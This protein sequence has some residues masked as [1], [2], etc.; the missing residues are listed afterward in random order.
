M[1]WNG[2]AVARLAAIA[3]VGGIVQLT[4]VS[5]I[6]VFGVVPLRWLPAPPGGS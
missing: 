3:L 1:T 2:A 4:T 6:S 5:Q